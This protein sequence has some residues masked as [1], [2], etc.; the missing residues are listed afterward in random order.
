MV[1][2][3]SCPGWVEGGYHIV[4]FTASA[5][6][7]APTPDPS[8]VIGI[9]YFD[10]GALPEA[11]LF[12]QRQRI[13]DAAAGIGGSAAV[14]ESIVYPPGMPA[15]RSE[16]YARRDASGLARDEFYRQVFGPQGDAYP[17]IEI[18]GKKIENIP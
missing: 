11:M 4:V 3:Y 16:L 17:T 7:H 2:I 5:P 10:P 8:E 15:P 14:N 18:E 9:D 12:G 1:G 13:L 6:D